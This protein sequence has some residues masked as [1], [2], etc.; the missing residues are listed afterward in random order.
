VSNVL[1]I[2]LTTSGIQS[3][4]GGLSAVKSA[5]G[6]IAAT[7]GGSAAAL[8]GLRSA[9]NFGGELSDLQARTGQT[10]RDLVVLRRAFD[11]AGVGASNTAPMI[12]L[13][14]RAIAGLNEEGGKTEEV[15]R[16]LGLSREALRQ[17]TA[18][19]QIRA[20]TAAFASIQNPAERT[21]LAMQL[22]GKSGAQMLQLL[23]DSSALSTAER[24]VGRLGQRAQDNAA[25]FDELGDRLSL[26]KMRLLEF[27]VVA[28]EKAIPAIETLANLIQAFN[29]G[30]LASGLGTVVAVIGTIGAA[31]LVQKLDFAVLDWATRGG[32]VAGQR[33][34][35][36]FL[37]PM[38]GA[39][40][41]L[42]PVGLGVA[43]VAEVLWGLHKAWKQWREEQVLEARTFRSANVDPA[44]K[45]ADEVRSTADV[46]RALADLRK[47]RSDTWA[48]F[49]EASRS[50]FGN[51]EQI[52]LYR[53]SLIEIDSRIDALREDWGQATIAQNRAADSARRLAAAEME[54]AKWLKGDEADKLR[55]KI[56]DAINSRRDPSELLSNLK[57][58]VDLQERSLR[59]YKLEAEAG[60]N[61]AINQQNTLKT[62]AEREELLKDIAKLEQ[63][64]ARNTAEAA[65]AQINQR[66]RLI[67]VQRAQIDGDFSRTDAEKFSDRKALLEDELAARTRI[68]EVLQ[69]QHAATEDPAARATLGTSVR[70]QLDSVSGTRNQLAQL[71]PSPDSFFQQIT[72]G[73]TQLRQTWGTFAESVAQSVTST[74]GSAVSSISD[75]ITGWIT[76]A[77]TWG[78]ALLNIGQSVL[79]SLIQNIV[80]MGV[81][82]VLNGQLFK[83]VMLGIDALGD[84]L[85]AARVVKENAAEA[86]TLPAKT[87]GAA[88]AGISS[89]GVALAFGALAVA[90]ILGL[91]G[92]FK[93][94][95]FTTQG[96]RDQPAGVVHAGEWVAPQ[97]M[98]KDERFGGV[99]A[100]LEAAR[101]GIRG[102]ASGG[103]FSKDGLFGPKWGTKLLMTGIDQNLVDYYKAMKRDPGNPEYRLDADGQW[104]DAMDAVAAS[105]PSSAG[106][107]S[108]A[109]TSSTSVASPIEKEARVIVVDY[110]DEDRIDRLLGDPRFTNRVRKIG[111][112]FPGDFGSPT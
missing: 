62:T 23:G 87:A 34:A 42:L 84:S 46:D 9:L 104:V 35:T 29:P 78:Q 15:F 43:I 19:D 101:T 92:G 40:A 18:P 75:G 99:I 45:S 20:L 60:R 61:T 105:A 86:A 79:H 83:T 85:R 44:M 82:M 103:Y 58:F 14:Q 8:A 102:F 96:P 97:W 90:L 95:G 1:N 50:F 25:K 108:P 38:T 69:K 24:E 11:N 74:I 111:R 54:A 70:S 109:S 107:L 89:Y 49:V 67:A 7:V 76:G 59:T 2:V 57:A 10:V 6:S 47:A 81:K 88:A 26:A 22:F 72:A 12:G 64:I 32:N 17:L 110:R 3:V 94:G 52:N 56:A 5:I 53:N 80:D 77:Q 31:K 65:E 16:Q 30:V 27:W 33:F 71:G 36:T 98:V 66:L 51:Q 55:S 21:A 13:L 93:S 91:A 73:I 68:L 39:L 4:L 48:K 112:Q 37:A 28:A 63:T 41:R 106:S 100:G